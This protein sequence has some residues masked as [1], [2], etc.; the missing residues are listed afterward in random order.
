MSDEWTVLCTTAE[1]LPG[2][3]HVSWFG[4]VPLLVVNLDGDFHALEDK[5]TH[6]DFELSAGVVDRE[7]GEVECIL[8]GAKFDVRSGEALCAPA[9]EPVRKY[10]LKVENGIVY[11]R[12]PD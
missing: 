4:D 3:N 12:E 9:Y 2:E 1:V 11:V 6:E 8:H 10:P 7:K 5:C